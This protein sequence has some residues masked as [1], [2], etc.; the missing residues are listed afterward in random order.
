MGPRRRRANVLSVWPTRQA[1]AEQPQLLC[2]AVAMLGSRPLRIGRFRTAAPHG[3]N[4]SP[5]LFLISFLPEMLLQ[6][7]TPTTHYATF[8]IENVGDHMRGK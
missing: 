1:K 6:R 3:P 7:A 2:L 4:D 8:H 5:T